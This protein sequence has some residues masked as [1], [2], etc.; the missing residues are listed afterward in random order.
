MNKTK[1]SR[2]QDE[3]NTKMTDIQYINHISEIQNIGDA[4]FIACVL[5][6]WQ[7]DVLL[8]YLQSHQ[9][10]NGILIV[11]PVPFSDTV[12]YR[13]TE[14]QVSLYVEYFDRVF[15]C[16][17]RTQAYDLPNLL[18]FL[19]SKKTM[20]PM[21]L[22]R[23]LPNISLRLLSVIANPKKKI[24]FVALDEGVSSYYSLY[25]SLFLIYGKR[26][27]AAWKWLIQ[28]SLNMI[29]S[30][31]VSKKEYFG[32][33]EKKARA[34]LP[35]REACTALKNLYESRAKESDKENHPILFFKDFNIIPD[36]LALPIIERI[37][38]ILNKLDTQ[39]V[40]KK[41]PSDSDTDFD[42]ALKKYPN[43][44]VIQS[45]VSGEELVAE[46]NPSLIIGG[47]STVVFSSSLIFQIPAIS[48]SPIY[49]RQDLLG[50]ELKK[51]VIFF[52]NQLKNYISF[53]DNYETIEQVANSIIKK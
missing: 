27:I 48:Y 5:T 7:F 4:E 44:T 22:L 17:T 40:I 53:C 6:S 10:K 25:D 20:E 19:F 31:F 3:C 46:I 36:K 23:P 47:Y 30:L 49:V 26:A 37:L 11:E 16:R 15:F 9:L 1:L 42:V 18:K 21:L 32:L 43:V 34:L 14:S 38:G 13:L 29:G 39:I 24:Y 2:F 41:H 12:K 50:K 33:F 51:N 8:A 52:E 35:N 45:L 28:I